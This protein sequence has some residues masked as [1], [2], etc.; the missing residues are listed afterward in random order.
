MRM[1]NL[2]GRL[3]LATAEGR[4]IDVATASEGR[5]GPDVQ[6]VFLAWDAFRDWATAASSHLG[7]AVAFEPTDLGPPVPSPRQIFAIGLNYRDHAAEA[8]LGLPARPMV[9]TKFPSSITGPTGNVAL[10][11][12]SVDFETELVVVIGRKGEHVAAVDAWSFVA[13]L[14]A[15]QDLSERELQMM[16]PAPQFGL[17]KS[18]AGFSPIG[19]VL[20]TPDEFATPDDI[21]LG[22]SVNGESRQRS[23]TSQMVF[24]V[25]ELVAY[26]SS[27]V[28]LLPGDVIFTGTPA[29]V[30]WAATPRRFF[31]P[32][33]E[34]VTTIEGIGEM[35]HRF[36]ARR[37]RAATRP[38]ATDG[39]AA[40]EEG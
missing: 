22:C 2:R 27:V 23:R 34:L 38:T 6:S 20:V 12:A 33:D 28:T 10:P 30:G 5:F 1:M 32:G 35:R 21:A 37:E 16:G 19:P 17:A 24:S 26:L 15:G 7:E 31:G 39:A 25:A 9:F 14:T 18:F 13:G 11:S 36:V 8:K 40:R 29:G 4:A 3:A